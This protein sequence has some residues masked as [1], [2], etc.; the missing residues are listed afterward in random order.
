MSPLRIDVVSDLV[1]PW[2]FIGSRRLEQSIESLGGDAPVVTYRPFLLDPSTPA[3]G[4]DLRQLLRRKYGGDPETMF[5]RVEAAA[6]E[7]GIPLDFTKVT[8][9]VSTVGAHTLVRHALD[10]GTQRALVRSLFAAYFLEGR[11][12]GQASVLAS[13]ARDHGFSEDEAIGLV[14]DTDERKRTR[15][16]AEES[17]RRGVEGVPFF[18]FGGRFALSGAQPLKVFRST[19]ERARAEASS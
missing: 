10:R 7:T 17:E 14:G 16:E 19:I 8:R 18:M 11:D 5:A 6:R 1:C 13:V 3:D 15:D 12:L 2:C 9:M 4:V